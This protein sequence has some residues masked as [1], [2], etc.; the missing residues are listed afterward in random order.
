MRVEAVRQVGQF[1]DDVI[2]ADRSTGEFP[3]LLL[4]VEV[5]SSNRKLDNS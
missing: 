2:V 3:N 1:R 4:G 5:R